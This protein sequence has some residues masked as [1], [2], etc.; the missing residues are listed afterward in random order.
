MADLRDGQ[1]VDPYRETLSDPSSTLRPQKPAGSEL[2]LNDDGTATFYD[3][4]EQPAQDET[5]FDN[6]A[7]TLD[8]GRL[9]SIARDLLDAIEIDKDSRKPADSKYEEGLRRTGLGNDA[10]GGASF[11]GASRAVHPMLTE[12]MLDYSARVSEELLPA[13][14]PAKANV[15][16][17]PTNDKLDRA[18][19]VARYMNYQITELMPSAY[20]E[21]EMGFTQEPL[22]GAF[23]TK[24]YD[25][26]GRPDVMFVPRDRVHRPWSDGDFYS[27]S[28]ITHEQLI[29][30]WDYEDNVAEGVWLDVLDPDTADDLIESSETSKANDRIIGRND[31]ME[32]VD[33]ER[34]VYE[35]STRLRLRGDEDELLPYIVTI[36]ERTEKVLAIYRNW[37]E[38]DIN[39]LRLDFLIEWG[40][41]P[42]RGGPIGLG[43]MIGSISGAATGT[44]RA[45]L[46]SALIA[47]M[48][49]GVKL[50]GGATS[51]GQNVRAQPGQTVEMQGTLANDD[52][53]KT[54]MQTPL[55]P[56]SPVL[57]QLLGFLVDSGRSVIRTTF[58][59]FNQI[60]GET[61]VGTANMMID[62]GLKSFKAVFGR[63][64]RSMNRFLRQLWQMNQK[65]VSNEQIIDQFGEL[66]VT[67]EDFEG[68]MIVKPV[69]DPRVFSDMQR[70]AQAQLLSQSAVLDTQTNPQSPIYNRRAVELFKMKQYKV[71]DPEQFLIPSP[72]PKQMNAAAENVAASQGLPIKPFAGQDH[73]AHIGT[74][75]AYIMSPIFGQNPAL[76]LK[77]LPILVGHL[78]D[79]IALWYADATL[80]AANGVLQHVFGDKRITLDALSTV[81][82]LEV[83]L[84]R[85]IAELSPH[86]IQ[87]A[88]V[89]LKPLLEV[90]GQAQ[91]LLKKLSPPTPMD[92]SAVAMKDVERQQQ[93]DQTNA[94]QKGQELQQKGAATQG[95]QA[96]AAKKHQ[97]DTALKAHKQQ[98]DA[99]KAEADR[100][101]KSEQDQ[102]KDAIALAGQQVTE[103]GQD[104]SADTAARAEDT[105]VAVAGEKSATDLQITR[106][107]NQ[108]A[109][110]IADKK[111]DAGEGTGLS[112]GKGVQK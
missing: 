11:N 76:A 103:R 94:Q 18:T 24:L 69:S 66:V 33:E 85:L 35:T 81:K 34:T 86:I 97:D 74:H 60:N 28:R 5:H 6:L 73:E 52:I 16:G 4:A 102:R 1:A 3:D 53:R 111:I 42:W 78:S 57:F 109:I 50:K 41:W 38:D 84:D 70:Q 32:N 68:P 106:E 54:Y 104:V 61:P 45:L 14:G 59:E 36:D 23:Y 87:H 72:E 48:P 25:N 65:S 56:P 89:S 30:R 51:G 67:K 19:R 7:D 27:Q 79:H 21:F 20:H 2:V 9:A 93:A 10:P 49:S 82:G 26:D 100:Q 91:A 92:P 40:F 77:C 107:D 63:Q 90:I 95:E 98:T 96:L 110:A 46:D 83:Q 37:E 62:Q 8:P 47:T 99:E 31:P 44:L 88:D 58:D 12:A 105:K 43:H 64:H 17:P 55:P 80:I 39:K 112:D 15:I 29:T 13:E 108:T 22:A 101:L 75:A 71:P